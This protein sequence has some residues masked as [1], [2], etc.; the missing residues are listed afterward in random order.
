MAG[1]RIEVE[2]KPS[3]ELRESILQ[4][5]LRFNEKHAGA[6]VLEPLAIL[7]RAPEADE[8]VGGLWAETAYRWMF[9]HL[10][11]VPE[12]FRGRGIGS[13]LIETAEE[14]ARKRGCV[15]IRLDTYS[16][17]APAFYPRLGY[18][19]L[20]KVPNYPPGHEAFMYFKHLTA[21]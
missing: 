13:R 7:L 20:G 8:V 11:V 2:E 5:L 6:T 3:L 1:L 10:V 16:F 4:P 18:E 14:V 9:I 19:L 17:Q 15:G 12:E 21:D